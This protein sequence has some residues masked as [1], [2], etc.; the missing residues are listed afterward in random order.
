M[1]KLLMKMALV[2]AILV[3]LISAV[4]GQTETITVGNQTKNR[5]F[6]DPNFYFS[7]IAYSNIAVVDDTNTIPRN[8]K[9]TG[10]Q[11]FARNTNPFHFMLVDESDIV[12]WVSSAIIPGG[13]TSANFKAGVYT[14]TP[15]SPIPV[16]SGWSIGVYLMSEGTIPFDFDSL[17]GSGAVLC[18]YNLLLPA[19]DSYFGYNDISN[20]TYSF[21]A[22]VITDEPVPG[23]SVDVTLVKYLDGTHAGV[24]SASGNSF[25]MLAFWGK[26]NQDGG[27]DYFDLGPDGYNTLTPYE[28]KSPVIPVGSFFSVAEDTTQGAVGP[29]CAKGQFSRLLGYTTGNTIDRALKAKRNTKAP[30]LTNIVSNQYIIVWN[31][32]CGTGTDDDDDDCDHDD[33][34]HHYGNDKGDHHESPNNDRDYDKKGKNSGKR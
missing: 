2:A 27:S 24:D 30:S 19:R 25:P 4:P 23:Q 18:L 1:K 14:Y 34:G 13:L 8:G 3:P 6:I 29:D 20:R 16:Q 5:E 26:D 11:Y 17:G 15:P 22:T 21:A 7:Q 32:T 28:A 33:N 10:F 9:V 12:R 31:K